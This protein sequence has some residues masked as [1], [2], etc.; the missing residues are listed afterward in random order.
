M[1]G[2][3][4]MSGIGRTAAG[5]AGLTLIELLVALAVFAVLGVMT[6]RAVATAADAREHVASE[7]RRWRAIANYFQIIQTDLT[8]LVIRPLALGEAPST[9]L[10]LTPA[11]DG[12]ASELSFIKLDGTGGAVRRRGYRFDGQHVIQLRWPGTDSTT[13]PSSFVVLDNVRTLQIFAVTVD[14]RRLSTWPENTRNS[15][16]VPAAIEVQLETPDVGNLRRL[17][18]LR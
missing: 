9:A 4:Q 15:D 14:G 17:F 7:F 2:A 16:S 6:Y 1:T 10:T 18:A 8:Q 13:V 11:S 3:K 12:S 5:S